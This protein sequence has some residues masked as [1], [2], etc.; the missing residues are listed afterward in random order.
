M[1]KTISIILSLLILLS[2]SLVSACA[3]T[4]KAESGS[5]NKIYFDA[6]GWDNLKSV[7]C[8]IWKRGGEAFFSWQ[9]KKEMCTKEGD[10]WSYDLSKLN[11]S[12][13]M[14]NGIKDGVDYLVIFSAVTEDWKPYQTYDATFGKACIGD[15]LKVNVGK[16]V[17]SP[18]DSAKNADEAVWTK[19]K[20]KYGPHLAIT[21]LGN[22]VGKFLCPKEKGTKVIGDWLPIYYKSKYVKPV[23]V[24]ADAYPKFGIKTAVDLTDIYKYIVGK[25]TGEDEKTMKKMLEDAFI[26]AYSSM[27]YDCLPIRNTMKVKVVNKTFKAKE[28]KKKAITY[29]AVKVTKAKGK[30]TYKVTK[31]NKS[32]AFK[33]G[34]ITVKKNTK[35]GTYKIKVKVTAAGGLVSGNVCY[36]DK[37]VKKTV[38]VNVK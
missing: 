37:T 18:V 1:K 6:S 9:V 17:E 4:V 12:E 28:L 31:K 38:T 7:F 34:K 23:N 30:V 20:N 2:A 35:K 26:K 16:K 5:N 29:K 14:P 3:D 15:T 8:H 11:D 33:K 21:S 24:L 36:Y 13:K 32:L 10:K 19:N 22:I 25:K 27:K